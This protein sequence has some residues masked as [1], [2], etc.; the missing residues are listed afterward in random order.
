MKKP[1]IPKLLKKVG[2]NPEPNGGCTIAEVDDTS[3]NDEIYEMV[4]CEGLG[5]D[6]GCIYS[7]PS[8]ANP[9]YRDVVV[10]NLVKLKMIT[11]GE[12]LKLMLDNN[13]KGE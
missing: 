3:S 6:K 2:F 11:K 13:V 5:C 10:A 1:T 8:Y 9:L 12:A 7:E 4:S